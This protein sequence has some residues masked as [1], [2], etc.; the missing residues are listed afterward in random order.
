MSMERFPVRVRAL[1]YHVYVYI[2]PMSV[3]TYM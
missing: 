3:C 2:I 1:M